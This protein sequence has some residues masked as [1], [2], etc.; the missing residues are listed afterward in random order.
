[1]LSKLGSLK[2]ELFLYIVKQLNERG[3]G[4]E[5]TYLG[6]MDVNRYSDAHQL[7]LKKNA[8]K[9]CESCHK[10]D[11]EFFKRVTLAII[12]GDG[13]LSRYNVKPDALRSIVFARSSRQFYVLGST[14]LTV[15]DW[16]GILVVCCGLLFPIAH[17][18]LRLVTLPIRKTRKLEE[19]RKGEKR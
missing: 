14:R 16:A 17:I 13:G 3:S 7:S 1:M 18:A 12:K 10:S 8:V 15:V 6:R 4:A 19:L 2:F 11:S 9:E 5:V